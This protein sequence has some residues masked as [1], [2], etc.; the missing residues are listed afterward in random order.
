MMFLFLMP[1]GTGRNVAENVRR[2][3]FSRFFYFQ[4]FR[5]F[6]QESAKFS[7]SIVDVFVLYEQFSVMRR[8]F[9]QELQNKI[10]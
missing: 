4:I 9:L 8:E 6:E 7:M 1:F 5:V 3:V 2:I 10:V